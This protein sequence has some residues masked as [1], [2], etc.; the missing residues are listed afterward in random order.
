MYLDIERIL[1][2]AKLASTLS[3]PTW[4]DQFGNIVESESE[5]YGCKV[6][7]QLHLPQCCIAMDEVGADLNMLN[8]GSIGG[9]KFLTRKGVLAKMNATKKSK[10]FT[11]LG[12]TNLCGD[13][14]M[15]VIIFEGKE[16]NVVQE[17]GIDPLHPLTSEYELEDDQKDSNFSFFEDNYGPGKLFPG[18]PVCTFEGKDIPTMIRYSENGSISPEILRD[19]LK[20]LDELKNFKDYRDNG[21]VPFLL[22]DGHQTR[23]H[24]TFL[25]YITNNAHPWK[26]S[27]GVPYGTSLWQVG[28]SYQQNG[29]Y[30]IFIMKLKRIIMNFRAD[31]FC[32]EMELLPTDII[33]MINYAWAESF[34]DKKGNVQAILELGFFPLKKKLLL[35]ND[36]KR[37]MTADDKQMEEELKLLGDKYAR[38]PGSEAN[39][40]Q[41]ISH[42]NTNDQ[43][44]F[45]E[46]YAASVLDK[47]VGHVDLENTRA[48]NNTKSEFGKNSKSLI[49]HMKKLTSAG[50]LV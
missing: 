13:A 30:K 8:D 49:K 14:I 28:D 32:S 38:M 4:M 19:I 3:E 33:L 23:F 9:S 34:A 11:M 22:V 25:D 7:T 2:D 27:I 31:L 46:G 44:N 16:C 10:R 15:C 39:A 48:R 41:E 37:T 43:L 36:L 47:L 18:G 6:S 12:L 50:Q 26:V 20:T 45:S 35:L 42:Q 40:S 1:V 29:H 17:S 5:S 24:T 21:A